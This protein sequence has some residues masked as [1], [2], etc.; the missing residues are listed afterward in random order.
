MADFNSINQGIDVTNKILD[1]A[2]YKKW[3]SLIMTLVIILVFILALIWLTKKVGGNFL[4]DLWD[5]FS[6]P[7]RRIK[8]KTDASRETGMKP[9]ITSS[10]AK[11]IA[12]QIDNCFHW[13]G[14]DEEGLFNILRKKI[15]NAADWYLVKEEFG[16]RVCS[17]WPSTRHSGD[18]EHII[19]HNF[20]SKDRATVRTIL[21]SKGITTSI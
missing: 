15:N 13:D 21:Q 16:T 5:F 6:T 18:I 2:D 17:H 1:T 7:F 4:G 12:D 20:G 19:S 9:E 10:K 8:N 14:D 11:D 3:L